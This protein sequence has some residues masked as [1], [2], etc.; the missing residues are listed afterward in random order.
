MKVL[1][2]N[3]PNLNML[4]VRE[5]E[6]YGS[7][8]LD[9]IIAR[10][11]AY[12]APLDVELV[13]KQSNVEGEL[14]AYI[15]EAWQ[16]SY[17]GMIINPAAYTH[18][19]IALRDA[20]KGSGVPCVEVHLSNTHAREPFRQQS[21]SAGVCL[22]QIQGFGGYGYILALQGLLEHCKERAS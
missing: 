4:G 1:I 7:E 3:G 21:M 9:Q 17:D 2:L 18:T 8:T 12:A 5:P 16:S 11:K 19:S 6:V 20:I 15:Q 10:L 22:G 13:C 14:I